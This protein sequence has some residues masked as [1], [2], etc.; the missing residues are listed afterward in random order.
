MLK[1]LSLQLMWNLR[2][3]RNIVSSV[4]ALLSAEYQTLWDAA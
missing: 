3:K 1:G 4:L 2:R